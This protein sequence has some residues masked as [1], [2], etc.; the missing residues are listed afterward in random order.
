MAVI[1]PRDEEL[2]HIITILF[3]STRRFVV[4]AR[5]IIPVLLLIIPMAQFEVPAPVLRGDNLIRSGV[6]DDMP[7]TL[8]L[9]HSGLIPKQA[10]IPLSTLF[11]TGVVIVLLL[12]VFAGLL[13]VIS[14]VTRGLLVGV[15]LV[16]EVTHVFLRL[17]PLEAFAPFVMRQFVIH[18]PPFAFMDIIRLTTPD[19]TEVASLDTI[20][21]PITGLAPPT[22]PLLLLSTDDIIHG[23]TSPLLPVT[24]EIVA[25]TRTGAIR[26]ARLNES[27]DSLET[28]TPP[29]ERHAMLVM[30]AVLV[31]RLT[32]APLAKLNVLKHPQKAL[33]LSPRFTAIKN[34]P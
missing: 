30:G 14:T 25:T 33:P 15:K 1:V 2:A 18:V 24:V 20:R 5:E 9:L 28:F 27:E 26:K 4:G 11:V 3:D 8:P 32:F 23:R 19:I 12:R 7:V 21:S 13:T 17:T 29:R 34:G 16:K 31:G 22:I 10:S 6:M